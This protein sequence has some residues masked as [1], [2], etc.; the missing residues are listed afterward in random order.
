MITTALFD[1]K[2]ADKG[3][4]RTVDEYLKWFSKTLELKC[5]MTIYTEKRFEDF[6][7]DNR[8]ESEYETRLIVQQ[9]EDIPFY[10]NREKMQRILNDKEYLSRIKD[11]DR[12]EC[13]LPE[14]NL[15]QYSKFGWLK[16]VAEECP[17][18]DYFFWMDAG[19]SRFF[20]DFNINNKWPN[21]SMLNKEKFLIQGNANFLR[22]WKDLDINEYA[23][24]N[25][26]VLVGTLFGA[27]AKVVKEMEG[28]IND[29]C[30]S[31]FFSNNCFNN[32]QLALAIA[33]K[34]HP[35]IFDIRVGTGT[36]LPLF[37]ALGNEETK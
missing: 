37:S 12:I 14:Y 33:A 20:E 13:Y 27:G 3:D 24:H 32:E 11:P 35:S 28:I 19:C 8:K 31:M 5:D 2:R 21:P 10:K 18:F 17:D 23:W 26:C 6:V 30:E 4:G 22:M 16:Q 1:I 9:L 7:L 15:I 29:V 36:H 34:L 25:E